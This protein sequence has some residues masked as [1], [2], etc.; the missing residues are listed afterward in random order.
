MK[1][2]PENLNPGPYPPY[3]ASTYTCRVTITLGVW[4][5]KSKLEDLYSPKHV[6]DIK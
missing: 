6:H 1:L 2:S 4:N 3:S 5:K